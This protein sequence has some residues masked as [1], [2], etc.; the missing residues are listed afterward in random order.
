MSLRIE[1][2]LSST[3]AISVGKAVSALAS[4]ATPTSHWL[5]EKIRER[6]VSMSIEASTR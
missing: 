1:P 2:V 3:R 4:E 6:P 5:S